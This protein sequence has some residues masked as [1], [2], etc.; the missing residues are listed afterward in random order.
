MSKVKDVRLKM[1]SPAQNVDPKGGLGGSKNSP[2]FGGKQGKGTKSHFAMDTPNKAGG[3]WT[4][5]KK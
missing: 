4:T 1:S 5:G 2:S 3:G